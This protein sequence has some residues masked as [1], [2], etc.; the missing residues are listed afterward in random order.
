MKK[1]ITTF[2]ILGFIEFGA[3]ALQ[4]GVKVDGWGVCFFDKYCYTTQFGWEK[5]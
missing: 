5:I 3:F 4:E 1:G 2:K